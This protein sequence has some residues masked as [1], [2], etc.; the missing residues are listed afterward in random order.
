MTFTRENKKLGPRPDRKRDI[1]VRTSHQNL[2][3]IERSSEGGGSSDPLE[4][5]RFKV[6]AR[7]VLSEYGVIMISMSDPSLSL[8]QSLMLE[9]LATQ[10]GLKSKPK[11][12]K[13]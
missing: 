6:T 3:M 5:E 10:T 2:P 1:P 11:K 13:S 12:G 9:E 7:R 4:G 8:S